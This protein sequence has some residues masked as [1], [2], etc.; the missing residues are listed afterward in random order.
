M[1]TS[2]KSSAAQEGG[3]GPGDGARGQRQSKL[4]FEHGLDWRRG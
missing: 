4:G 1:P 2:R 3:G